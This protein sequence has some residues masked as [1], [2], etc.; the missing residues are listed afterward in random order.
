MARPIFVSAKVAPEVEAIEKLAGVCETIE[1]DVSPKNKEAIIARGNNCSNVDP[2]TL[3]T[4]QLEFLQ[5][6]QK[7]ANLLVVLNVDKKF[8]SRGLR[9]RATKDM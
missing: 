3:N 4:K 1:L 2:Q 6:V 8:V 7:N 5:V 9:S